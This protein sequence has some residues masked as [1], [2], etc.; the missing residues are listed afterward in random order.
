MTRGIFFPA[1]A[2]VIAI[3]SFCVHAG[4][5]K[6]ISPEEADDWTMQCILYIPFGTLSYWRRFL[7]E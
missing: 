1:S 7:S 5:N 3:V 4:L 6:A 2:I